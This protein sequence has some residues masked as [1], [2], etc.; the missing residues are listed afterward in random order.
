MNKTTWGDW[1]LDKNA[2]V[3]KHQVI[4]YEIYLDEC[5]N[6]AQILDWIIQ[7]SQKDSWATNDVLAE[8]VRAL[9]DILDIQGHFCGSGVS[10][11]A[12]S[13]EIAQAYINRLR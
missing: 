13:K 10:R 1:V 11:E 4:G 9:D 2:L 8:L 6:S 3:L 5:N 7:I 12:N